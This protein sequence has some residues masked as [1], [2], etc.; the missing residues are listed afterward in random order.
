MI[1]KNSKDSDFINNMT[2]RFSVNYVTRWGEQIELL[3]RRHHLD[4]IVEMHHTGMGWWTAVIDNDELAGTTRYHYRV[5]TAGAVSRVEQ[6]WHRL[7]SAAS[8][9]T[10]L[11]DQWTDVTTLPM[12]AVS[13]RSVIER[14]ATRMLDA[15]CYLQLIVPPLRRGVSMAVCGEASPL[16]AWNPKRAAVMHHD[17]DN[18]WSLPLDLQPGATVSTRFKFIVIDNSQCDLLEWEGGDNRWLNVSLNRSERV[19]VTHYL[20]GVSSALL[21]PASDVVAP[22]YALRSSR[23]AGCGDVGDLFKLIDWAATMRHPAVELSCLAH[24]MGGGPVDG[25][26]DP[27]YLAPTMMP[28]VEDANRRRLLTARAIDLNREDIVDVEEVRRLKMEWAAAVLMTEQGSAVTRSRDYKRWVNLNADWLQPYATR[29]ANRNRT[30]T[31]FVQ[32]LLRCQLQQVL[33]HAESR[34]VYLLVN[35]VAVIPPVPQRMKVSLEAH[36]A[37]R[38]QELS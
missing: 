30:L 11:I 12:P 15:A 25:A 28:E 18:V 14:P 37:S 31:N 19:V 2:T 33:D 17:S 6:G 8:L 10:H 4:V 7:P 1:D 21:R 16:G 23:D 3:L 36:L 32:Y 29:M 9:N 24:V 26:I 27:V 13:L 5:A 34:D 20:P 35:P 22:L 38:K